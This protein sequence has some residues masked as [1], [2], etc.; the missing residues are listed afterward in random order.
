M[1]YFFATT[2]VSE[3]FGWAASVPA[4]GPG[5]RYL[6]ISA[7]GVV[8]L[9]LLL[10]AGWNLSERA[11]RRPIAW[12]WRRLRGESGT[13]TVEFTLVL[14]PAMLICLVLL[15]T[16]LM[17]SGNLFVHYAAYVA[18]RSAIVEAPTG[19]EGGGGRLNPEAEDG[20]LGKAQR[21]AA[22]ALAPVSGKLDGA[23][24]GR[25][26]ALAAGLDAF[27]ESY[28]RSSPRWVGQLAAARLAYAQ[29]H[30][31]VVLYRTTN[32]GGL[33]RELGDGGITFGAKDPVTLGVTHR[34]HLSIPY[35]SLLF[36]DGTHATAGGTTAYRSI[37]ATATLPLEG[38]DRNLPPRPT[39]PDGN[40]MER[41][42]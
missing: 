29:R 18:T 41:E 22:F 15:Q 26:A 13:A 38:I 30:T 23:T 19:L 40:V 6:L 20:A 12:G 10:R 35:A 8:G 17:F 33:V 4:T 2:P 3:A 24:G 28:E 16:V 34:L 25:P 36:S 9:V 39:L 21:A 5:G 42:P 32:A 11:G 1:P 37:T 7:A 27:F 14:L 31:Q